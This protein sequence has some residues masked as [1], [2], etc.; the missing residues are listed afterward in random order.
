MGKQ[1]IEPKVLIPVLSQSEN[2]PDFLNTAT[3]GFSSVV[4]L[5]VINREEMVGRVGFLAGEIRNATH[6]LEQTKS[7]LESQGKKTLDC[8]EWGDTLQKIAHIADLNQCQK[9]A[10]LRQ[11]NEYFKKLVHDLK[12]NTKAIVEIVPIAQ[13][14]GT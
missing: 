6:T 14:P 12:E 11:E 7:F 8:M 5:A 4:L 3:E 1:K 13:K 10:L 9:I 2:N